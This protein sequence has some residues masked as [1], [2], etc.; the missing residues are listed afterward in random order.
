MQ[1][2]VIINASQNNK[3]LSVKLNCT[4]FEASCNSYNSDS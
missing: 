3:K 1:K 4:A 2:S